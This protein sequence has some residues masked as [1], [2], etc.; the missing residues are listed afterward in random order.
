VQAKPLAQTPD[1]SPVSNVPAI[2]DIEGVSKV[3]TSQTGPVPALDDVSLSVKRGE[4]VSLLGPSGC[5]KSTLLML[6]AGLGSAS[7]GRITVKERAVTRPVTDLGLMFQSPVLLE[8][9]T[10]LQNVALQAEA[11]GIPRREAEARAKAL[12]ELVGLRGF[13]DSYPSELSGGM[14]QRVAVCRALLHEPDLLLMDEPF[15]ALDALSRDQIGL[16]IQRLCMERNLS[17]LFVTHSISEA[18]FLSDR[19]VVMTPRPGRIVED[20]PIDLPKPRRLTIRDT[21]EF[22]KLTRHIQEIFLRT[23]VLREE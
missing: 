3:Y 4:F 6:V 16:D 8:W 5:G 19:I 14:Q 10:A 13:A 11:K 17:V 15:A 9:R 22:N 18:V 20:I 7:R 21:P 12:L 1:V 2:I 23:G